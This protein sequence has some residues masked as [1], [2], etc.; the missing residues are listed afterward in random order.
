MKYSLTLVPAEHETS[1]KE[2]IIAR[3]RPDNGQPPAKRHKMSMN[4]AVLTDENFRSQIAIRCQENKANNEKKTKVK[5]LLKR[6][7]V[8]VPVKY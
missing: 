4:G 1:F 7:P 6:S 8:S 2:D 3:G 5:A